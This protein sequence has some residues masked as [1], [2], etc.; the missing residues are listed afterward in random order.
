MPKVGLPEILWQG[1]FMLAC[2]M[3]I[4]CC[5]MN[6]R[7]VGK[8][9]TNL[10]ASLFLINPHGDNVFI[11]KRLKSEYKLTEKYSTLQRVLTLTSFSSDMT[12]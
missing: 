9:W 2:S 3:L 6:C 5:V 4:V 12:L 1:F 8:T 10:Y 11:R 7:I